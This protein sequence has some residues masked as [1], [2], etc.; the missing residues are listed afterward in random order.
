M[1][2]FFWLPIALFFVLI[3]LTGCT[4]NKVNEGSPLNID[5]SQVLFFW[6]ETCPHCK[7]V[8]KYFEENDKLDEKLK[9]KKMEISGNKE[10][11]KY[12]E[13]VATKCKLSQMN[14]GVPLLYKDQKCTMGDAPIISILETM[15]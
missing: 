12:F 3:G 13:Q 1:R 15:K 11:M 5:D 6:S 8:E 4:N 10:N 7:N 14:A 9:I 2:K